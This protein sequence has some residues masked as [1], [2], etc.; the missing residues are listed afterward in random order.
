MRNDYMFRAVLQENINVLTGLVCSL[1]HLSANDVTS[2]TVTNP[3]KLGEAISDKE[4]V[5]DLPILLNDSTYINLEMQV[6]NYND[7][8]ERSLSYLCRSF[9]QL[10][11][12]QAYAE[13]KP[14]IHI[15]FLDY[16]PFPAYPE[17][18]SKYELL[19]VRTLQS[20][21]GKFLIHVLD[22][23]QIELATEEEDKSHGIDKWARLFKA[24]TWEE[25]KMIAQNDEIL[26]QAS[27]SIWRYNA[28]DIVRQQCAARERAEIEERYRLNKMKALTQENMTLS[29]EIDSLSAKNGTLTKENKTLTDKNNLLSSELAEKEQLILELKQRLKETAD[30]HP[31]AK[32]LRNA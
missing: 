23:T 19:N 28:N 12:G 27:E 26:T 1:L 32:V 24:N 10:N 29:Q 20:Y 11:R 5:L 31:F 8:P 15:G 22:L 18:F 6:I 17:F 9:D 30:N 14:V 16:T 3:I 2:I 7:W 4:F 13:A 25:L 21:S